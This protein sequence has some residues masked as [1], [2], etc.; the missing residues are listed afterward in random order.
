MGL[1]QKS[2]ENYNKP[3]FPCIKRLRNFNFKN[4]NNIGNL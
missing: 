3:S 1:N 4:V 2:V